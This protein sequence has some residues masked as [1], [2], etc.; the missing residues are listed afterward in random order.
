MRKQIANMDEGGLHIEGESLSGLRKFAL[1][2]EI[3]KI[4]AYDC[5]PFDDELLFKEIFFRVE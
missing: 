1:H 2:S 3:E 5:E 4:V